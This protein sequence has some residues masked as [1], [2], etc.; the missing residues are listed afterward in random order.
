MKRR[1]SEGL[2]NIEKITYKWEIAESTKDLNR[3]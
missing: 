3:S 2:R 1:N